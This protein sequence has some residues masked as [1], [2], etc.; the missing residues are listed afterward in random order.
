MNSCDSATLFRHLR[1]FGS[2]IGERA[3]GHRDIIAL[4]VELD[5]GALVLRV[6]RRPAFEQQPARAPT[7]C[8]RRPAARCRIPAGGHRA[9]GPAGCAGRFCGMILA[10]RLMSGLARQQDAERSLVE[11][12]AVLL[13]DRIVDEGQLAAVADEQQV[14]ALIL[15]AD[16]ARPLQLQRARGRRGPARSVWVKLAVIDWTGGR[17]APRPWRCRATAP[18]PGPA[19]ATIATGARAR[20]RWVGK[21]MLRNSWDDLRPRLAFRH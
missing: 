20:A 6:D 13:A 2:A 4:A 16:P 21:L 9:R 5:R 15:E 12:P 17:D 11:V 1:F 19:A 7:G 8:G 3:F 10:M 14:A 18:A